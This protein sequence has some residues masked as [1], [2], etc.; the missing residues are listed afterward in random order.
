MFY[1]C[2]CFF[3]WSSNCYGL[4]WSRWVMYQIPGNYFLLIFCPI[5]GQVFLP[6]CLAAVALLPCIQRN[7]KYQTQYTSQNIPAGIRVKSKAQHLCWEGKELNRDDLDQGIMLS[8]PSLSLF[9]SCVC[10][11]SPRVWAMD[12]I[13]M[14]LL[15]YIYVWRERVASD[16]PF[17]RPFPFPFFLV[18]FW[19]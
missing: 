3:Y 1:C 6:N 19:W 9:N 8:P 10:K 18:S 11:P 13:L 17:Y 12:N 5:L 4:L 16:L 7:R 14:L 2:S 15:I